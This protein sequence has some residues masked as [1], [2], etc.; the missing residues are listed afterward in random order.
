MTKN[1][2]IKLIKDRIDKVFDVDIRQYDYPKIEPLSSILA[3]L[4][5]RSKRKMEDRIKSSDHWMIGYHMALFHFK[6]PIS[7]S[8]SKMG[9]VLAGAYVPASEEE[10]QMVSLMKGAVSGYDFMTTA[11][12]NPWKVDHD[13]IRSLHRRVA[14]GVPYD[15]RG[16][17]RTNKNDWSCGTGIPV[18]YDLVPE[19]L[20]YLFR[21]Y[22]DASFS[23]RDPIGLACALYVCLVMINSFDFCGEVVDYLLMQYVLLKHGYSSIV[24]GSDTIDLYDMTLDTW[25]MD[26]HVDGFIDV[27]VK[28][29]QKSQVYW[30][31]AIERR[32]GPV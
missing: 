26:G 2:N 31:E 17:Y 16:I 30:M 9:D 32:I 19:A 23:D 22:Y 3:P 24:I 8:F 25:I 15:E 1:Q 29:V 4:D 5:D 6:G 27:I 20:D 18:R 10:R 12:V 13:L 21:K 11:A 14:V 7:I 28:A